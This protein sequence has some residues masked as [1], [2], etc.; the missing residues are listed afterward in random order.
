MDILWQPLVNTLKETHILLM[1]VEHPAPEVVSPTWFTNFRQKMG[2]WPSSV[3]QLL[4]KFRKMLV[5][6]GFFSSTMDQ[7]PSRRRLTLPP[8]HPCS[9]AIPS[10]WPNFDPDLAYLCTRPPQQKRYEMFAPPEKNPRSFQW[11]RNSST[12]GHV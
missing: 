7:F 8:H 3:H 2:G 10:Q 12:K 1:D 9:W 6:Y 4:F 5:G 11:K